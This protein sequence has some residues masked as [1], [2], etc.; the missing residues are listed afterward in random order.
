MKASDK[1]LLNGV[2]I[3]FRNLINDRYQYAGLSSKYALPDSLDEQR[4]TMYRDF[5]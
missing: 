2:I 3:G 5:F 1:E 4:M